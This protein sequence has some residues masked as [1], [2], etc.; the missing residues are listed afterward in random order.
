MQGVDALASEKDRVTGGFGELLDARSDVCGVADQGELKVV[1]TADGAGNHHTGTNPDADPKL[2]A[3][4]LGYK[5]MNQTSR[6]YRCVSMIRKVIR[7]A[8]NGQRPVPK[9]LVDM[10]TS[11]NDRRHDNLEQRIRAPA[12]RSVRPCIAPSWILHR[13]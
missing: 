11:V 1:S 4:S 10:T 13:M 8:E 5:A 9:E 3:E 7:S 2:A 12:G 6:S